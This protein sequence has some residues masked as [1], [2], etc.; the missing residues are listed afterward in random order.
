MGLATGPLLGVA[1]STVGSERS[2][3]AAALVNVARM[4][5]ATSGVAVLG[6]VYAALHGGAEGL[7]LAMLLG[8]AAQLGCATTAWRETRR[9]VPAMR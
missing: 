5:G 1:V 6:T 3:T 7:G 2:G 4:A 9:L 8:G